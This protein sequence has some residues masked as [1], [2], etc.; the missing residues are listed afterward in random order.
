MAMT[1]VAVL[2]SLT[3]QTLDWI[4]HNGVYAVFAL[5]AV[6]ALL[7]V[8]GELIMLYA[9]VV[10]A[11]AV[12]GQHAQLL[13]A[14]LHSGLESFVVLALAGALGYLAGALVGWGIGARGGRELVERHGRLL[15]IS[16]ETFRRAERWFSRYGSRAVLL[17]ASPRSC[18]RSSRCRPVC[19]AVPSGPTRC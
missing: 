9:G 12:A 16:P 13:G 3:S 11:G 6:D 4:A 7:P 14:P 2:A 8:G 5:M 18:V 17:D 1:S 15:H 19:W 10:A